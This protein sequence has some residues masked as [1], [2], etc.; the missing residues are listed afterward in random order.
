MFNS[1]PLFI[2]LRYIRGKQTNGFASFISWLS[3]L[4]MMLGVATLII[5]MSV[6]NGFNREIRDR[7][8]QVVPHGEI[9]FQSVSAAWQQQLTDVRQLDQVEGVSPYVSGFG[10]LSYEGVNKGVQVQGVDPELESTVTH[11]QQ[12]ML[13][14]EMSDLQPG[15]FGIVLGNLLARSLGVVRGDA[16]LLSLPTLNVTPAGIFPRFKRVRVVGV[17]SVGA[18]VDDGL[19]L[20]HMKDAQK[21]FH[22]GNHV[23]GLRLRLADPLYADHLAPVVNQV[24]D[25]SDAIYRPWSQKMASLFDAI[26]MEKIVVGVLLS[27]IIAVAAFNIIAGLVLMVAD[28]RKDIAVLRTLGADHHFV[29]RLVLGQGTVIGVFG[30]LIGAVLGC[31]LAIYIGDIVAVVEKLFGVYVF[32]PEVYFISEFPSQLQWPDVVVT[33]TTGLILSL[34]ASVYPAW[35]AGQVSPAEALRYDH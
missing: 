7:V 9:E 29:L 26:K 3:F 20:L 19:A 32:D 34:L 14:G 12:H 25:G 31:L 4:A 11:I 15:E 8:L 5:V 21:I 35:R 23:D 18:Q 28:K 22:K 2:A 6:M 27:S 33:A 1:L 10:M 13:I 16:L 17:Y 30:V 24:M